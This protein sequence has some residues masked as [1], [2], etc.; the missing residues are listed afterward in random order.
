MGRVT[1]FTE[2]FCPQ[3]AIVTA[4][5]KQNEIPFEEVNL[6]DVAGRFGLTTEG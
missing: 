3:S 1:I 5:L 4:L 2:T 6:S